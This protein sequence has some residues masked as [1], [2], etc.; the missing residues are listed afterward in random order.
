MMI[1]YGGPALTD[2]ADV[3]LTDLD[4]VAYL[5]AAPAPFAAEGIAEAKAKGVTFVYITNNAGRPPEEVADQLTG[6]DIPTD[7]ADVVNTSMTGVMQLAK[8]VPAGSKVLAI[9]GT[10]VT[11]AIEEGGF[12]PVYS[13]DDEP[14]AVLQGYGP[15][16]GWAELSEAAL[17]VRAGAFYVAT[18]LDATLPQERG[19]M[20]GNGSLVAAVVNATGVEPVTS[21]KPK[22]DMYELTVESTGAKQPMAVGDRIDTDIMGANRAGILSI[23]V[24]TGVSTARDII[25]STGE[26]RP[27]AT[28]RDLRDLN[29]PIPQVVADSGRFTCEESWAKV[30][31]GAVI[32]DGESLGEQLTFPQYLATCAAVWQA[33]DSDEFVDHN[34]IPQLTVL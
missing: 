1:P 14:A 6:L 20:I 31:N 7:P 27:N 18:N 23:H 15:N 17:A 28:L 5:G 34:K 11:A 12:I 10:G 32:V 4:G 13:A 19:Q 26:A 25:L 24:L 30:E 33:L 29:S 22:P 16:V 21:G 8:H 9:G 3:M 2:S